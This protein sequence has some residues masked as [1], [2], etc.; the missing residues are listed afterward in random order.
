MKQSRGTRASVGI[1]VLYFVD[2]INLLF[3]Q[4]HEVNTAHY[5]KGDK[6]QYVFHSKHNLSPF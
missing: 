2:K 5:I 6:I 1:A 4:I 3:F